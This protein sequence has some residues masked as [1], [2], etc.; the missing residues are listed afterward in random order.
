MNKQD[1]DVIR[2]FKVKT[3]KLPT[4]ANEFLPRQLI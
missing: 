3:F 1:T 2:T 4:E